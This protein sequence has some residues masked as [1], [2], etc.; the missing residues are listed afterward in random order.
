MSDPT[1]PEPRPEDEDLALA[2]LRTRDATSLR[3]TPSTEHGDGGDQRCATCHFRADPDR[4][5]AFCWHEDL[6]I[7]V[8]S[9]WWCDRWQPRGEPATRMRPE[10]VTVAE[11][12]RSEK[13]EPNQWVARPR[14]DQQC[15]RCLYDLDHEASVSYCWNPRLQVGVGFDHSCRWWEPDPGGA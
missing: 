11:R 13:V 14:G 3:G 8:G 9:A 6:E 15:N 7:L 10:Q 4:S 5:L 12:L 1:V 2:F